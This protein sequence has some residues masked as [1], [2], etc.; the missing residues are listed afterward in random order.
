M[1]IHQTVLLGIAAAVTLA[2]GCATQGPTR[3]QPG[4]PTAVT[5]MGVDLADFRNAAGEMV[6]EM[7]ASPSLTGFA[8]ANQRRPAIC[9]GRD[10]RHRCRGR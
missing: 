4:G 6:R 9:V 2:A 7:L 10:H 5:T 1:K 8:Q 3:I